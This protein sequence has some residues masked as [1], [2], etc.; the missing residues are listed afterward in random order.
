MEL[1]LSHKAVAEVRRGTFGS[2]VAVGKRQGENKCWVFISSQAWQNLTQTI[3]K[4]TELL[5]QDLDKEEEIVLTKRVKLTV[6]CFKGKY[7][8]GLHST[9]LSGNRVKGLNLD[10][11]EWT[12]LVTN[13]YGIEQ[14]MKTNRK[15]TAAEQEEAEVKKV[16]TG[17][18]Q[19]TEK[20]NK[21]ISVAECKP[22]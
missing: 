12:G 15:R 7:Y 17:E 11:D 22:I 9:D 10:M 6:V 19:Q 3:P 20:N 5:T 18:K 21:T 14:N 1:Q 8:I 2:Y 4:V 16:K 13:V